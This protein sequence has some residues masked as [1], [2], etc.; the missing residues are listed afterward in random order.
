MKKFLSMLLVLTLSI[1]NS[2]SLSFAASTQ[3]DALIRKL[4]E[5]KILTRQEAIEL[6]GEIAADEKLIKEENFKTGLPEWVQN[7]K[8]K[9]D[10]RLRYQYERKKNDQDSRDRGRAR[11]RLGIE[12]QV[13]QKVKV[14]AGIASGADDPRSTN[15]TFVDTFERSDVRLDYAFG[16]YAHN[17][18]AKVIGGIFPKKDYLW[19]PSDLL[20]DTDINPTGGAFHLERKMMD[21]TITP[22]LNTGVLLV[23]ESLSSDKQDPFIVYTQGGLKWQDQKEGPKFDTNL[24][25]TYYSFNGVQ[26]QNLDWGSSTNSG[27]TGCSSSTG[28]CT[29]GTTYDFDSIVAS[30]EVGANSLFGGLPLNIDD[31]IAIFSDFVYNP[32]PTELN[33][34]WALGGYF[35]HKKVANWKQWQMRYQYSSLGKDAWYDSF[36]DSDRN[37]GATDSAGHETIFEYGLSKNVSLSFD[38]YNDNRIKGTKNRQQLIQADV[39]F[40]F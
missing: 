26:G 22:Y 15:Q 32:N 12:S 9:G 2:P 30:M 11:Y 13:N 1:F 17:V 20:W 10:F 14:G 6:K 5:K 31:R 33:T 7:T 34:G 29:T 25:A 23:D 19:T 28:A 4:V 24:A 35:G 8:L 18:Y 37:G 3:V 21:D 39:N 38:Y 16:E 36:P 27:R 40:K